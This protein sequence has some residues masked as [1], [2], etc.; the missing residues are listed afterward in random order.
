MQMFLLPRETQMF[1]LP[2][3][4]QLKTRSSTMAI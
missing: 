1:L 3:E 2:R 4:T